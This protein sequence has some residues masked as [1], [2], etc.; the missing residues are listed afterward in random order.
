MET[1]QHEPSVAV[2]LS[3]YGQEV[4]AEFSGP[5]WMAITDKW[6]SIAAMAQ[7]LDSMRVVTEFLQTEKY[8]SHLV[9][10]RD[11]LKNAVVSGWTNMHETLSGA[12]EEM[13]GVFNSSGP[14]LTE[15]IK[16]AWNTLSQLSTGGLYPVVSNIPWV[17]FQFFLI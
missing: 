17:T 15:Y 12:V 10:A 16:E 2:I 13:V 9:E 6:N 8:Y 1:G 7:S 3:S 4:L 5:C 11:W 14:A